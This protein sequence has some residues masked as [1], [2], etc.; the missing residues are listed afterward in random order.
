MHAFYY[1]IAA[2][3]FSHLENNV[4]MLQGEKDKR[5]RIGVHVLPIGACRL[6]TRSPLC[7]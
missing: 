7:Y 3:A 5:R 6:G 2:H 1:A 4:L